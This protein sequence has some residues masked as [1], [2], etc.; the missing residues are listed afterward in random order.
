MAWTWCLCIRAIELRGAPV[1]CLRSLPDPWLVSHGIFFKS[2]GTISQAHL[3]S[4]DGSRTPKGR[5]AW[6]L[7]EALG[8][9]R[10]DSPDVPANHDI[11]PPA[12]SGSS[13]RHKELKHT[14]A[15]EA[16]LGKRAGTGL[17]RDR[18]ASFRS[19]RRASWGMSEQ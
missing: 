11:I 13:E 14:Q 8:R 9:Y 15:A 17:R 18:L 1:A 5:S 6:I 2:A 10:I 19:L 16:T 7:P 3:S 4:I 12:T